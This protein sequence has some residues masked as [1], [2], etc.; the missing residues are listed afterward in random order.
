MSDTLVRNWQDDSRRRKPRRPGFKVQEERGAEAHPDGEQTRGSGCS[1]RPDRKGDSVGSLFRQSCK[2]T[3]K[4]SIRVE[5]EWWDEVAQQARATGHQAML[6]VGFDAGPRQGRC[7]LACFD[8]QVAEYMTKAMASLLGGNVGEAR[9]Y[10][11][12][13]IG[14]SG[15]T[16]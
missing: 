8:L 2:T 16:T 1:T 11:G 4:G 7:D 3:E 14:R 13:A 15:G 9:A 12:L 5:R 10:A 6:V